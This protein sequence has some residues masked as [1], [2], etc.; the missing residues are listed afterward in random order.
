MGAAKFFTKKSFTFALLLQTNNVMAYSEFLADRVRRVLAER[1]TTNVEEKRMM[2]GMVFMV[3][4]KMC[5]GVVNDEVMLRIDH[6]WHDEAITLDGCRTMEMGNKVMRGFVFV[7]ATAIDT[8]EDLEF[9]VQR[10]LD[11]NP[12]A[13]S[14]KS[15]KKKS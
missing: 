10:A 4:D 8:D 11:F 9:W 3:N 2:S 6:D 5:I 7:C 1:K 13:V 12:R 14:S 15:K